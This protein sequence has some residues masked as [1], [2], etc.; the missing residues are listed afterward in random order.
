MSEKK[1][2][3]YIEEFEGRPT[4]CIETSRYKNNGKDD[5]KYLRFG[6]SKAKKVLALVPEIEKFVKDNENDGNKK[7]N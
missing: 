4:F 1:P 6:P 5:V 2:V 7:N 3:F